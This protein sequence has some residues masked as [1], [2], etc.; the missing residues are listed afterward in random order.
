MKYFFPLYDFLIFDQIKKH[1][2]NRP[3][4]AYHAASVKVRAIE[5]Q[6]KW[7]ESSILKMLRI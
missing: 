4:D 2:L 6:R 5:L 7:R 1:K 3:E